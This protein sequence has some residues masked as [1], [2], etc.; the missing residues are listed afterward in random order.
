MGTWTLRDC[1]SGVEQQIEA[2]E[3]SAVRAAAHAWASNGD[4]GHIDATIWVD[5][6]VIDEEGTRVETVTTQLDPAAPRCVDGKRDSHEWKSPYRLLGGLKENPG[7]WGHG[8][9]VIIRDV[10]MQC[11]CERTTDTWAQRR[12]TGEQGLE[13]VQYDA[14]KYRDEIQEAATREASEERDEEQL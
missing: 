1:E 9:G 8:G 4:Y 10:C 13:S 14:G 12:D 6:A 3:L 2:E 11:G 7:V 5:T